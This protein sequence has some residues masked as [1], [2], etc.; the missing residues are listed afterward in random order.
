MGASVSLDSSQVQGEGSAPLLTPD[1]LG[2]TISYAK[3][4]GNH[5]RSTYT[6]SIPSMREHSDSIKHALGPF[7]RK[8]SQ[9]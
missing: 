8:R 4:N 9:M 2:Q 7:V 3:C 1:W 5:G 6:R